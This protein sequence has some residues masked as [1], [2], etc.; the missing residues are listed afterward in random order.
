MKNRKRWW[1]LLLGITCM[2]HILPVQAEEYWPEGPQI[3]GESAIVM[4]ASTG[5]VLFEKNSHEQCYPASI[6][7][8]MTS[9]LA[10][11]NSNLDEEVT[12]SEDAVYKTEGSGISRDVG[13][14]M[15]MRE[16]LYGLMLESAN[17]CGYAIAEHTGGN[18][19]NFVKM[20]ND[21]AK[22]LG[23]KDT[24]FNNPHGLPDEQHKTSV[25]DMALI[26]REAL[27][28]DVFRM[29]VNTRRHTIPPTNKHQE[30]TYLSN[31]HKMR[32]NY[33]GDERYLYE[34]CIGGKTGYT[35]VAGSTLA[36]FAE[37]DGMT[38]ICVVM[39]ETAPNH[40]IDTRTLFDY[41]FENFQIWNVSENEK[42]FEE[43]V[44]ESKI[45]EDES[46]FAGLN[47]EGFVV[48]PKAA[49][50]EDAKPKIKKSKGDSSIIGRIQYTYADRTVGGTDI[51]ISNVKVP[52]FKFQKKQEEV[53]LPEKK[54]VKVNVKYI[55]FGVLAVMLLIGVVFGLYHLADNFYLIKYKIESRR[56][57]K[58]SFKE[59]K[60]KK[61]RHRR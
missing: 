13:E 37:K 8:I 59:I 55:I 46:S 29:I 48:L 15:T 49:A 26:S 18:Y 51:V 16:C 60:I 5:T 56:M 39:R 58:K 45:F 52:E 32:N 11:K 3:A 31:H 25:Y 19:D 54:I 24:H 43:N 7:K 44:S 10:V 22:R 28:N 2:L 17:E 27:K 50:F 9:M 34:Y 42:S 57:M 23:C 6:T 4:E 40:Y 35:S 12:F 30:E 38:L 53:K 14:V 36:T 47:K 21:E 20:M 61:H 33:Q 1:S 41:C